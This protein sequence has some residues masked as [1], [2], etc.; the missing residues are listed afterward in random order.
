MAEEWEDGWRD[1][2]TPTIS[3]P[4]WGKEKILLW[5]RLLLTLRFGYFALFIGLSTILQLS[6]DSALPCS[7]QY[8]LNF[9]HLPA[10]RALLNGYLT[11]K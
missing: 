5:C 9:S 10:F 3:C 1:S 6:A 4:E 7:L 11:L 2:P 8:G